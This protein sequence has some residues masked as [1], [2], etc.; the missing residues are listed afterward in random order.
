VDERELIERLAAAS[1]EA[2]ELLSAV[3]DADPAAR[4]ISAALAELAPELSALGERLARL[5]ELEA[6]F[7]AAVEIAKLDALKEFAYGASHEINNPLANISA[8]A[9]TLLQD[10]R[11]PERRRRLAAINS[12]AFRAH[13]MIADVMLFARPPRMDVREIELSA[14]VASLIDEMSENADTQHT[15]LMRKGSSDALVASVDPVHLRVALKALVTNAL[16]ALAEGGRI[17]IEVRRGAGRAGRSGSG[18]GAGNV[19]E[20]VVSD[21][22][23]GI[24]PEVRPHIFDP[25]FSGREAGRGLGMGLPKCWRIVSQHGGW[26]DVESSGGR[27]AIFKITLPL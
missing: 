21:T 18:A 16:E 1:R 19:A 13:E 10:E 5:H 15:Q 3:G 12:Q 2:A 4:R 8:R 25:F 14:L 26:I 6:D 27:G 7:Q 22:G 20:I 23:P 9:Q 11:D 17:E 24:P